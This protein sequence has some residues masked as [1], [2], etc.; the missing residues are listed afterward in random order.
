MFTYCNFA[1]LPFNKH[2]AHTFKGAMPVEA[3]TAVEAHVIRRIFG[4]GFQAFI[5]VQLTEFAEKGFRTVTVRVGTIRHTAS[6]VFARQ[7]TPVT[8]LDHRMTPKSA[9]CTGPS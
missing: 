4:F 6:A 9:M 2:R 3:D 8:S 7:L 5:S 1:M